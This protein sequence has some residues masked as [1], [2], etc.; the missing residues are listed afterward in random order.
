MKRIFAL[1]LS[2]ALLLVLCACGAEAPTEPTTEATE[3][4]T[5][6]AP[7]E[8]P[9]TEVTEA[10]TTEATEPPVVYRNPLNGEVLEAPYEGRPVAV[11]I[12]NNIACLP[13]AGISEADFMYELEVEGDITR[14]LAIF[15]DLSDVGTIGPV[16]SDRV[17]FNNIALS[18]DA[19]LIHCGGSVFALKGML[20]D[21]GDTIS[22]WEHINEQHNGSYFFR[23]YDRYYSGYSWEHTLFTS[24]EQLINAITDQGYTEHS[25]QFLE[26]Q[27]PD[28]PYGL[29]F[30]D[31]INLN[32]E[33][34][35][36]V[37]AVFRLGK[38]TSFT[39]DQET[40]LY[41]ASQYNRDHMDSA[42]NKCVAYR[43]VLVLYTTK[44]GLSDGY[45]V[46]SFYELEGEGTGYFACNGQIIPII[47]HRDGYR[48]SF[49]YTLEDGTPLTFGVG[50]TY[51][52]ITAADTYVK[53]E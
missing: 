31:E 30:A 6:E 39:F 35:N 51:V 49:T 19:P 11:V 40:G 23:D 2:F 15:S 8:A 28:M 10:P 17:F 21:N 13:Q 37:T 33:I 29:Q 18:Y 1:V 22:N 43:N 53:Y 48:N 14:Y 26:N 3:A 52:G 4:P 47:W 50:A 12:N 5:T 16:R 46:R 24:G 32:G 44:W 36:Q 9:T 25:E 45:Y 20:D 7:T 34:A 41:N 38:T 27:N 42:A